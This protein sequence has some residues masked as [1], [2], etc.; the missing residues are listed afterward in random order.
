MLVD[1]HNQSVKVHSS[2]PSLCPFLPP[3]PPSILSLSLLLLILSFSLFL[4]PFMCIPVHCFVL[5]CWRVSI[6]GQ[7]VTV[8][9]GSIVEVFLLLFISDSILEKVFQWL[10]I[11]H[12]L[13][14]TDPTIIESHQHEVIGELHQRDDSRERERVRERE[15]NSSYLGVIGITW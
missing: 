11:L 12:P 14:E 4:P 7:P 1:L 13:N 6:L 10:G 8:P 15:R 2:P 3:H 9:F 5:L